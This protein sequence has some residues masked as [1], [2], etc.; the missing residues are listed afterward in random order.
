M[1]IH[2]SGRTAR[3]EQKGSSILICSPDEVQGVR[4]LIAKVHAQKNALDGKR[5][6]RTL[7]ID[8]RVVARLKPRAT[9]AKKL[10]D[11]TT[12]KEKGNATDQL[13]QQ[14]AEDLG[15]D[16]DSEEFDA[17]GGGKTGRGN[18]RK[19]KERED[20]QVGK[21]EIGAWKAELR[22]LLAQRVNTGV[23][24]RYITGSGTVDIDALLRGDKGDFLG[25]VQLMDLMGDE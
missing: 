4:R 20:R 6:I 14:A 5:T 23:S 13:F 1:Y 16:Y 17:M 3:A 25:N 15:I 8:R 18:Q 12:A 19:T 7:E 9:L 22:A 10:A 21:Q 2:R 24:E 11:V